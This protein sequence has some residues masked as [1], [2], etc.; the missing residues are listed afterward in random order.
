MGV[1]GA[2]GA[3]SF[4]CPLTFDNIEAAGDDFTVIQPTA[5]PISLPTGEKTL[6][7]TVRFTLRDAGNKTCK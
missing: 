1:P 7:V 2:R 3:Y 5:F 6:G 4:D